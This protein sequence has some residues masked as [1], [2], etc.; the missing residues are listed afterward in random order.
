MFVLD[1]VLQ[2]KYYEIIIKS[3]QKNNFLLTTQVTLRFKCL[4]NQE[5]IIDEL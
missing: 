2:N 5:K 3:V 4:K 1:I